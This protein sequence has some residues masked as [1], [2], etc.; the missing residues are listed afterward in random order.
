MKSPGTLSLRW[1][2]LAAT[3]VSLVVLFLVT[4]VVIENRSTHIA[5]H[6]LE[7]EAQASLH[8]YESLWRARADVLASVS[9][10]LA[11]ESAVFAVTDPLGHVLAS[12]GDRQLP[13]PQGDIPAVRSAMKQFPKQA[14]GFIAQGGE[15]YQV[16][17]TPVYVD[18]TSG[19]ALLNVLVAGYFVDAPLAL[20]L[21]EATG[22]SEF[23][24]GALDRVVASSLEPDKVRQLGNSLFGPAEGI[25]KLHAG[26][27]DYLSLRRSLLDMDGR[28]AGYVWILR[29]FESSEAAIAALR[30]DLLLVWA[31]A[32]LAALTLAWLLAQRLLRPIAALD[33]AAEQ[34][35]RQNYSYRLPVDTRD[36][37]GRLANAFNRMCESLQKA[38]RDLIRQERLSTVSRL[39]SSL[40]HDLRNPLAVIYASSEMLSGTDY[41]AAQVKR[42]GTNIFRSAAQ[43]KFMLED[44]VDSSRGRPGKTESCPLAEIVNSAWEYVGTR[45]E[46]SAVGVQIGVP[47]ECIVAVERHRIERVFMNLFANAIEAMAEGGNITVTASQSGN[48]VRVEV[49]DTG[50]GIDPQILPD[51]FE[52]LS[53]GSKK[54]GMGLGLALSRQTVVDNGGDM[55]VDPAAAAGAR[56]WRP[57][58]GAAPP[59]PPRLRRPL[60]SRDWNDRGEGVSVRA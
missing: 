25:T 35:S 6:G 8:A 19:P 11:R 46:K 21:K 58:S 37:L 54:G 12:F 18:S 30:R 1:K 9:L 43:V 32:L 26:E 20:R 13:S 44:L 36:E 39:S 31:A 57:P 15:L 5:S 47:E 10:A 49:Q 14:T 42:L 2:F 51:L 28:P 56:F 3:S 16:V 52:P 38:E 59:P 22:G 40:V 53:L 50:P 29:S 17:V 41:S 23:A 34:V 4:G 7:Q 45:A 48:S 60:L 24:F 33:L 55:G 27:T